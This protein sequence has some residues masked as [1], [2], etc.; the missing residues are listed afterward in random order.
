MNCSFTDCTFIALEGRNDIY[1]LG[2]D[3]DND[4]INKTSIEIDDGNDNNL[5]DCDIYILEKFCPKGSISY[6]KHRP[7]KGL[8]SNNNQFQLNE[9]LHSIGN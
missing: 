2:C 8:C 4:A 1:F 6:H 5:T 3:C 9:I 7:I